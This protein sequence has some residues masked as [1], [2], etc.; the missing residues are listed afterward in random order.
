MAIRVN[1]GR[2][3]ATQGIFATHQAIPALPQV[4]AEGLARHC[5]GDWGDV[6]Q[7]D[8]DTNDQAAM[9]MG[10][11][12]SVYIIPHELTKATGHDRFWII[13]EADR[14]VTTILWPC[15]Y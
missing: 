1:T 3:C 14:S 8:S 15:E 11:V 4:I 9:C 6:D 2:I 12:L 7:E 10:Q 13:T 5:V